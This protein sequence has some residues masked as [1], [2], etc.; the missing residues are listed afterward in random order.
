MRAETIRKAFDLLL[1]I[2]EDR[3]TAAEKF[4]KRADAAVAL[5]KGLGM[6]RKHWQGAYEHAKTKERVDNA[7]KPE[8]REKAERDMK[9]AKAVYVECVAAVE[10]AAQMDFNDILSQGDEA[11][12][13]EKKAP[14]AVVGKV[15]GGKKTDKTIN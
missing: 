12:A 7:E 10:E 4:K 11:R 13:A 8:D 15:K 6:K 9:I 2:D 3:A 1:A 14:E 5:L